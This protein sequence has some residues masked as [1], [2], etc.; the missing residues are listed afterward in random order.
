MRL[1]LSR[2]ACF[3][4]ERML[5]LELESGTLRGRRFAATCAFL[6]RYGLEPPETAPGFT[7]NLTEDGELMATGSLDGN[8]L[9]YIAVS[10]ESQGEGLCARVVSLLMQQAIQ[11]GRD[12]LLLCTKPENRQMFRGTGFYP[13]SETADML[14]MENR[15]DG[16][17]AFV[18]S[19]PQPHHSGT[20]GAIV[21]N[22]NPFTRGHRY[23]V[24]TAAGQCDFLYVFLVSE[25][26][27][28]FSAR[29]RL[30]LARRNLADLPH[31][32]VCP[33][34]DYMISAATFPTYFLKDQSRAAACST[35]LDLKIF[36]EHFARPLDITKRFVGEEPFCPVT[37]AYNAQMLT[38]LPAWGIQPV[39]IPRL[40]EGG[41]AISA[42]R[43][44]ELLAKNDMEA[45]R[46]LVTDVTYRYL[47]E[48]Y[49]HG[50]A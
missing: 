8:V 34:G 23:L 26:R 10:A 47:C 50:D 13:V 5:T 4:Q 32:A 18:A 46:P 12:H 36:A 19:L 29:D 6:R 24:E 37:R 14:L 2:I 27:S 41:A 7:L 1:L 28:F 21:A 49:C 38:L 40:E 43:V 25:D 33:T 22:C 11:E 9:K 48:E 39:V 42:S 30:E 31:V 17:R 20:V 35:E 45:L 3:N 44:R 16:I 15:R